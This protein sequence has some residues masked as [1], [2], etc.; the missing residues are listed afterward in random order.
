M[1]RL[2]ALE[3]L[4]S[5]GPSRFELQSIEISSFVLSTASATTKKERWI[6]ISETDGDDQM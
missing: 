2:Q 5:W 6:A 1:K 3:R 4:G